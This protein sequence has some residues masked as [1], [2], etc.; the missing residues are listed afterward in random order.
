MPRCPHCGEEIDELI[1][2]STET[3]SYLFT[4]V[5]GKTWYEPLFEVEPL[6]KKNYVCPVC[7]ETICTSEGEASKF[8]LGE[9][10]VKH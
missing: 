3:N 2:V 5:E 4:M 1:C 8:L 6:E 10:T 9:L 7:G